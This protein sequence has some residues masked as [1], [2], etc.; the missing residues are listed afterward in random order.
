MSAI[1]LRGVRKAY[2]TVTVIP[3]IDLAIESGEFVVLVGPSGC[4]KSTLLRMIAGLEEIS[5]GRIAIGEREVGHLPPSDRNVAMVFQDY[6]LYPHMS[7]AENMGFGLRMRDHP[8]AEIAGK[9][10]EA[11]GVLKLDALL[12]RRPAQLSGGQ[13]QRV[14]MGRAIV[15]D[16]DAFLFDEP[17]SNLDASLRV[18]MRLE[19]AKLHRRIRATTIYVTHDQVEAMTLADRIVVMNGGKMEQVGSPLDL[20]HR[21]ETLFVARFIGSPTM[22]TLPCEITPADAGGVVAELPAGAR[23]LPLATGARGRLILGIR[24]EDIV[25]CDPSV[26][27]FTGTLVVVEKLGSQSFGYLETDSGLTVTV[28]LDRG[29][30]LAPGDRIAAN[31]DP[32]AVHLFDPAS[33]KRVN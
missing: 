20:Y 33:E 32:S 4:G 26:A 13:R 29:T 31:G 14:A 7:V 30:D 5:G 24:P 21:P 11:S 25:L 28:A 16:P 17:L 15:R 18:E 23:N 1:E 22:N 12:E 27:W 6:A 8:D 3:H 2:G 19:I 9:V 10:R